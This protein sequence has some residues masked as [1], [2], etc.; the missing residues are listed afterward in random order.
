LRTQQKEITEAI[1][2]KKIA[3]LTK[4]K[5]NK[6]ILLSI[7]ED[8]LKHYQVWK[9]Y[10]GKNVKPYKIEVRWYTWII[11]LFGVTFGLKLMEGGEQDAIFKYQ[12]IGKLL[13]E[14]VE[15]QRE[16][17]QHEFQLINMIDEK[18]L[19]YLGSVVL[20]LNDALVEL[21]G[22]LAGLTFGFQNTTLVAF[23]GLITGIAAAMS[24]AGSEYLS[25]KTDNEKHIQPLKAALYTGIAYIVTVLALIC[26]YFIFTSVYVAL[27]VTIL[28]AIAIIA[29][30]NFYSSIT[31]G[32]SFKK[33]FLEMVCISL[34]VALVS[35]GV[36]LLVKEY[37]GIEV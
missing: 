32:H 20:G 25:T 31:Q 4:D 36:G 37:F 21:T 7:A 15:I 5:H 24:M 8:E 27:G 28:I 35:F 3:K 17:E 33:R 22:V 29:L 6:E 30:F 16:E 18:F 12:D 34:G 11:R 26:P 1:V 14:A 10:T 23:S 13:P 19:H 9:T 2:Y